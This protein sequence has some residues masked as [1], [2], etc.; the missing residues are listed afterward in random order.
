[1]WSRLAIVARPAQA[2]R[3]AI[4]RTEGTRRHPVLGGARLQYYTIRICYTVLYYAAILLYNYTSLL[5]AHRRE[6]GPERQRAGDEEE[7]RAA[8]GI[9]VGTLEVCESKAVQL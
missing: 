2:R 6:R 8:G 3:A 5:A 7:P 9:G 4:G 1:M